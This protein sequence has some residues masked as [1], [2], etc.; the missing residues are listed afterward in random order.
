MS[1]DPDPA[2]LP[3][4]RRVQR[5]KTHGEDHRDTRQSAEN[6]WKVL[7][8]MGREEEAEALLRRSF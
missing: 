5:A 8:M 3:V 7:K 1:E 2:Q 4:R 6:L